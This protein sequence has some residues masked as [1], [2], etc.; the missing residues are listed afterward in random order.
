MHFAS[1]ASA[2]LVVSPAKLGILRLQLYPLSPAVAI[3]EFRVGNTYDTPLRIELSA[4]GNMDKLITLA[5]NNFTLQ[6]NESKIVEYTVT[7]NEPGYYDGGILIKT[8]LGGKG[9]FGY[10]ADLAVFVNESNLQPYFI[11]IIAVVVAVVL[12]FALYFR[13][14]TRH[15]GARYSARYTI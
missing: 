5:E 12:A 4:V 3:R 8:D 14:V 10:R 9:S 13:K 11:A 15:K 7:I 2:N 1:F 6:P